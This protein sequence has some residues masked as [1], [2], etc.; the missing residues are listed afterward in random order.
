MRTFTDADDVDVD[1]C[2]RGGTLSR[3]KIFFF[4]SAVVVI[5][6]N[7]TVSHLTSA[8]GSY[9]KASATFDVR[10]PFAPRQTFLHWRI[11]VG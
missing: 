9:V 3:H 4:F 8:A 1:P 2:G 10:I 6:E 11:N 7:K 5:H